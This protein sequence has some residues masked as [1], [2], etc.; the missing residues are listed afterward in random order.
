MEKQAK[1]LGKFR[2]K[3]NLALKCEQME[4]YLT[5]ITL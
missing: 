1:W 5:I 4:N 2:N 3:I